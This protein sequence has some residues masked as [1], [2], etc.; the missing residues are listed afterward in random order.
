MVTRRIVA[1]WILISG[2][3]VLKKR[4]VTYVARERNFSLQP[5]ANPGINT[6]YHRHKIPSPSSSEVIFETINFASRQ[7]GIF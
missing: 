3:L 5:E 7:E 1:N 4:I 6:K 2:S